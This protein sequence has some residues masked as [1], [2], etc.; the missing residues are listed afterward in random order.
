VIRSALLAASFI[1]AGSV[2]DDLNDYPGIY[3]E[4]VPDAYVATVTWGDGVTEHY[5]AQGGEVCAVALVALWDGRWTPVGRAG[6]RIES[7]RCARL[8]EK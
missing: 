2:S 8:G 7:A 3:W 6:Q 5:I 1:L 4:P